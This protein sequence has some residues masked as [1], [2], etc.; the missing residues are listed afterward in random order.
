MIGQ[1]EVRHGDEAICSDWLIFCGH[2]LPC[3]LTIQDWGSVQTSEAGGGE[4]GS[5]EASSE[6]E[7][8]EEEEEREPVMIGRKRTRA[9]AR[10]EIEYETELEPRAKIKAV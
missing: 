8:E 7:R 6:S 10:V 9:K 3:I 4:E 1:L 2:Y 5:S